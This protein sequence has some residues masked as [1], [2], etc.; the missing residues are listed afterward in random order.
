MFLASDGIISPNTN[1]PHDDFWYE[2]VGSMSSAGMRVGPEQ[3]RR[4]AAVYACV[5]VIS[6]SVSML[7][8][9]LYR[10]VDDRTKRRATD[11]PLYN[12]L[13]RRPNAWQ[14][15]MEWREMMQAHVLLRGNGYSQIVTG[16]AGQ[17]EQLLP[18]HPDCVHI[19]MLAP[20]RY[21]F[22]VTE[23]GGAE[24]ILLREEVFHLRGLSADGV[25][26][27]SPIEEQRDTIGMGL[28]A[29]D[30]GARFFKND[31][32]PPGW[33]EHPTHFKD[34][35]AGQA[36]K[37]SWQAAQTGRNRGK[38]AVLQWGMKYHP[39]EI[40]NTDA[41]FIEAR[42]FSIE[43]V[44][45]IFR[46]PP[47]KIQNLDKATFSNIEHLGIEF[48]TD[49][50]M[51][52]LVRWEQAVDR[53][54][55]PEQ[56]EDE[57]FLEHL[58]DMLQRG[59][60]KTRHE[61]YRSAIVTGWMTRNEARVKENMDPLD[62]LD[63]PLEPLSMGKA[64]SDSTGE[65]P[66]EA[67][68]PAD[69]ERTRPADES[70]DRAARFARAAAERVVRKEVAAIARCYERGCPATFA[71]DVVEFYAKHAEYVAELMLCP[72]DAAAAW[73]RTQREEMLAA[74]DA[75]VETGG[76]RVRALIETW[77]SHKPAALT[78]IGNE[79]V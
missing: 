20:G 16:R 76:E 21:R 63:E 12:I 43:E 62:G 36:F 25:C 52:W 48:V 3:A 42:K 18:L 71:E 59:D 27:L 44:A 15:A 35:E 67:D 26:G 38:T 9:I 24:R 37:L 30:Y 7:P 50:L 11:H 72:A 53:D 17:V 78:R 33:I 22:R 45:R 79:R 66:D 68:D 64:G 56:S 74:I 34:D 55:L 28:A 57:L 31:A 13:R 4:L 46:V 40:K 1:G 6:E 23:A 5:K 54:L 47:H 70:E 41:Q 69:G 2:P 60:T 61:S 73:C 58:V 10:R 39:I 32:T 65:R 75:E 77:P 19:E 51:P 8:A 29:Q 14:T 49:C